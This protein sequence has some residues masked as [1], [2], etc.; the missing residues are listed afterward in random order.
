MIQRLFASLR[1][2]SR[3]KRYRQVRDVLN[4]ESQNG[5]IL[6]LGGGPASFFA[7]MFP[8]PE[9]VVL[10]DINLADARQAR[11]LRPSMGAVVANGE[12]LPFADGTFSATVC[13]SV[14]EHVDDPTRLSREICRVS[15]TYFVQTPNGRFPLET[16]SYIAIPFYNWI[17]L[18]RV[19]RW[20]CRLFGANYAYVSSVRYLSET[21]L[22]ELFPNADLIYEKAFG[23]TKSFY[24]IDKREY[25]NEHRPPRNPRHPGQLQRF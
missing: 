11:R 8:C 13:N 25:N 24:I 14:I 4:V 2:R 7:G 22:K 17:P 15:R 23:L 16:H 19:K 10:V 9:Q 6:D 21:K 3:D 1:R 20:I 12:Q 18:Q 5:F